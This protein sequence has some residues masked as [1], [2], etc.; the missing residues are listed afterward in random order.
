MAVAE[1][2]EPARLRV[3]AA[4]TI[5]RGEHETSP[6]VAGTGCVMEW[7]AYLAGEP[8]STEPRCACPRLTML[9]AAFNDAEWRSDEERDAGLRGLVLPLIGSRVTPPLA[10][11]SIGRH[12]WFVSDRAAREVLPQALRVLAGVTRSRPRPQEDSW[13][14]DADVLESLAAT[15]ERAPAVTSEATALACVELLTEVGH[16]VATPSRTG[17]YYGVRTVELIAKAVHPSAEWDTFAWIVNNVAKDLS[18]ACAGHPELW[19]SA[20][21]L[22]RLGVDIVRRAVA[23][24]FASYTAGAGATPGE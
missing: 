21:A 6:E 18:T 16:E 17:A 7:V 1:D 9:A 2:I 4:G 20:S 13:Q 24:S 11:G 19:G 3:F 22:L 10:P 23:V 15:V 12:R 8:H 14:A 5:S